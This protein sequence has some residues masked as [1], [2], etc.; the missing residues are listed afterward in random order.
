MT[1]V[2]AIVYAVVQGLTEL[3]PISSSGYTVLTAWALGWQPPE[4]SFVAAIHVGS[5]LAILA[6]FAR[7]WIMILRTAV[8]GRR[9]PLG[10]DDDQYSMQ[11][12]QLRRLRGDRRPRLRSRM[13][14]PSRHLLLAILVSTLPALALGPVLYP[15]L[16]DYFFRSPSITGGMMVV[17]G[18]FLF[19]A[20]F[21]NHV[22][23]SGDDIRYLPRRIT[24]NDA[25]IIGFGQA[26]ALIPGISR[27]ASTIAAGL[28]RGLPTMVA[29][30]YSY[31]IA[32]PAILASAAYAVGRTLLESGFAGVNWGLLLIG[33][34]IAFATSYAAVAFFMR[35]VRVLGSDSFIA[36]GV[37]VSSTGAVAIALSY[38]A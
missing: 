9:I 2:E 34:A 24:A 29:V 32:A 18:G 7:D 25:I 33:T 8:Q 15:Y 38:F 22:R 14:M 21:F 5:L 28:S 26:I 36:F 30:R 11:I 1:L 6:Y 3:L 4:S 27:A 31:M 10:G 35:T 17:S 12:L 16:S 37:L 23:V 13:V 20:A 19:V